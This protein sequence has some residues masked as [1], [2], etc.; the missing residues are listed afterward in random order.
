MPVGILPGQ[1]REL[2]AGQTGKQLVQPVR[3]AFRSGRPVTAARVSPGIAK[4][5]RNNGD[6]G[7]VV[8]RFAIDLHPRPQSV[9]TGIVP[10]YARRM[11]AGAG[12]LTDDQY[13]SRR[14]R[15]EHRPRAERQLHLAN[16]ARTDLREHR[17]E[18]MPCVNLVPI[19]LTRARKVFSRTAQPDSPGR[20]ATDHI[21][22][23]EARVVRRLTGRR[24]SPCLYRP[25]RSGWRA[26]HHLGEPETRCCRSPCRRSTRLPASRFPPRTSDYRSRYPSCRS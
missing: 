11:D 1:Y 18:V 3:G 22:G 23:G 20:S 4:P 19:R 15:T 24:S 9:P 7:L 14:R 21:A 26:S 17:C 13:A 12:G 25:P 6:A 5:H 16:P 2:N 10:G 8:K